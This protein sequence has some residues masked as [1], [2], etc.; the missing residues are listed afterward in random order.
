MLSALLKLFTKTSHPPLPL[1]RW[2]SVCTNNDILEIK[3]QLKKDSELI[4]KNGIDPFELN[5][6]KIAKKESSEKTISAYD[7]LQIT[8]VINTT[9]QRVKN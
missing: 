9:I 4:K 3:Y 7:N 2:S 8:S 6:I 5:R 1:G